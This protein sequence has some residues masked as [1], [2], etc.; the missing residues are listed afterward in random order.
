MEKHI[1]RW[2]YW[3]GIICLV[4]ALTWRGI[5]ALGVWLPA[6]NAPQYEIWYMS[7]FRGS[8]LFFV[9]SIATANYIWINSRKP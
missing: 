7:F 2:S 6:R 3:L 5:N 9:A 4:V 1:L 8:L